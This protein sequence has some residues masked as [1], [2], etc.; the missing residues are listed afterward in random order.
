MKVRM[1]INVPYVVIILLVSLNS[2]MPFGDDTSNCSRWDLQKIQHQESVLKCFKWKIQC[3]TFR[4]QKNKKDFF[5][6]LFLVT[7]VH[8]LHLFLWSWR[9]KKSKTHICKTETRHLLWTSSAISLRTGVVHAGSWYQS[10]MARCRMGMYVGYLQLREL[11]T[12]L[13][14]ECDEL[15]VL[16]QFISHSFMWGYIQ[17]NS[18]MKLVLALKANAM[19]RRSRTK[20]T[21]VLCKKQQKKN[22]VTTAAS[23]L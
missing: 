22:C 9:I 21:K 3:K 10:S 17:S 4:Q 20:P 16:F 18:I 19:P 2:R 13:T 1:L 23:L 8:F 12:L 6:W 14:T 15:Y 5:L 7:F 11:R